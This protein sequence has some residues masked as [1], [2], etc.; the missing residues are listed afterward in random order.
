MP[1][2]CLHYNEAAVFPCGC[3]RY[4]NDLTQRSHIF[5]HMQQMFCRVQVQL[6]LSSLSPLSSLRGENK[7]GWFIFSWYSFLTETHYR[8]SK[9]FSRQAGL[10]LILYCILFSS[11]LLFLFLQIRNSCTTTALVRIL[12]NWMEQLSW[13]SDSSVAYLSYNWI[14]KLFQESFC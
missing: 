10:F 14:S 13:L 9:L 12:Y 8:K 6:Q 3:S 1:S 11:H 4:V 2:N 5:I 7:N